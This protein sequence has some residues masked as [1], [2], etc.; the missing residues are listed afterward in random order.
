MSRPKS[1]YTLWMLGLLLRAL[2]VLLIV[3]I[4]ALTFWR[5]FLSQRAP[6]ELR[7]L[8]DNEIL[9]AAY[10]ANGGRITVLTQEQVPYS[11]AADKQA[12]F[13]IDWCLFLTEADQVQLLLFYNDSTLEHVREDL[14]LSETP[15]RGEEV[16]RLVLT[17]Y[18][19]TTPD[20]T[21]EERVIE[22]KAITPSSCEIGTTNLYTFARYTFDGV[23]LTDNVVVYLDIFFGEEESSYST[24][25]LYHE[26]SITDYRD[27]SRKEEKRIEE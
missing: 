27:L 19:N 1:S 20:K 7:T 4:C 6:K 12:Y 23:D 26:E 3:G 25:R 14:E 9:S 18:I 24:L 10:A 2:F 5:V 22:P 11:Q 17:Q 8:A 15:P 13:N 21:G 16:F